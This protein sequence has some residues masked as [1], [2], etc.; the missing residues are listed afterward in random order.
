MTGSDVSRVTWVELINNC[1][2]L[3]NK[4]RGGGGGGGAGGGVNDKGDILRGGYIK[5][6][7]SKNIGGGVI[8]ILG[9]GAVHL[10]QSQGVHFLFF[11]YFFLFFQNLPIYSYFCSKIPIFSY[12]FTHLE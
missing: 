9:G 3:A 2:E 4:S 7:W 12:F 10:Y 1:A 11:S 8:C 5:K 6:K